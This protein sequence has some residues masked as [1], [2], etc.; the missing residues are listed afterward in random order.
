MIFLRREG[1]GVGD[2]RRQ[3]RWGRAVFAQ[4]VTAV[5]AVGARMTYMII[6]AHAN[7]YGNEYV[8]PNGAV[9]P[10]PD[11]MPH[12]YVNDNLI[13]QHVI[14]MDY[15]M[16]TRLGAGTDI[17]VLKQTNSDPGTDVIAR[18]ENY[19]LYDPPWQGRWFCSNYWNT[20][21]GSTICNQGI[22]QINQYYGISDSFM[23]CHDAGH[24][25]GLI[26]TTADDSCMSYDYLSSDYNAHDKGHINARYNN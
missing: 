6:P 13:P 21:D 10:W 20:S 7:P 26:H 16:Q 4:A 9:F 22:L 23:T 11:G 18:D 14:A 15:A 8:Y 24:S 1:T 2:K 25:V 17:A 5:A 19:G 12:S 3:A